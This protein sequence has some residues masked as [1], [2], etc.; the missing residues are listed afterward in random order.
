MHR[1]QLKVKLWVDS[2][3]HVPSSNDENVL[4]NIASALDYLF[5]QPS[6]NDFAQ[7]I[8][9]NE[10][11]PG[12]YRNAGLWALTS[13]ETVNYKVTSSDTWIIQVE[14][15]ISVAGDILLI[16]G[17]LPYNIY[18]GLQLV[19]FQLV[20]IL[21]FMAISY[22]WGLHLLQLGHLYKE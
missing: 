11:R 21:F 14:G 12:I 2:G 10:L 22:L 8:I 15:A 19:Q 18:I 4:D 3:L 16:G 7:S 20:L 9:N 5:S 13:R 17:A 6:G 1:R